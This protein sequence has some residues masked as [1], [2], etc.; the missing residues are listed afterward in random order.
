[1]PSMLPDGFCWQSI[2][3]PADSRDKNAL[4]YDM[5]EVARVDQAVG[6]NWFALL[7]Y[8][9]G[10]VVTRPCSSREAGRL[11]CELW[12]ARH[13]DELRRK[14]E[15]QNLRWLAR[16]MWRGEDKIEAMRRLKEL[17]EPLE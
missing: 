7:R 6:G 13:A 16:Q 9:N 12:A 10:R 8:P 3:G 5:S 15:V 17:G 2:Y 14:I 1:M 4:A 11:G